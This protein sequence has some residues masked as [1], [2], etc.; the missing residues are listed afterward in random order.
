MPDTYAKVGGRVI[1]VYAQYET[2]VKTTVG[3]A[4]YQDANND[5]DSWDWFWRYKVD[6]GNLIG[7]SSRRDRRFGMTFYIMKDTTSEISDTA[8][9]RLVVYRPDGKTMDT[10]LLEETYGTLSNALRYDIQK[11][12]TANKEKI[13]R[14]GSW[15]VLEKSSPSAE[16]VDI[17]ESRFE[18]G[19]LRMT[20]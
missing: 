12:I 13:V 3:S 20:T 8:R 16:I 6:T 9:I 15:I 11:L 2:F 4:D 10:V 19:V 17:S 18:I 14:P 1:P 5:T 7:F